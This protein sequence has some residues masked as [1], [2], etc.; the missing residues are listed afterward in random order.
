MRRSRSHCKYQKNIMENCL[1]Q[2]ILLQSLCLR[3]AEIEMH[4]LFRGFPICVPLPIQ[5]G[6]L[7]PAIKPKFNCW[8]GM[9]PNVTQ[10]IKC[11]QWIVRP[12]PTERTCLWRWMS[13]VVVIGIII[14]TFPSKF[15]TFKNDAGPIV[16]IGNTRYQLKVFFFW[17]RLASVVCANQ[18][19][20]GKYQKKK[21]DKWEAN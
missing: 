6:T 19:A 2:R 3:R 14:L 21:N 10:F 13:F 1:F 18:P 9:R 8:P 11:K 5:C 17:H 16:F 7:L 12:E 4:L 20:K 15:K